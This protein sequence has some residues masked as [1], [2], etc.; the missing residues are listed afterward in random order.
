M[1]ETTISAK[2]FFKALKELEGATTNSSPKTLHNGIR[3]LRERAEG[4]E[5]V[6][7][8]E[9]VDYI[10]NPPKRKK[11]STSSRGKASARR[12]ASVALSNEIVA[13]LRKVENDELAFGE[14]L[15]SY[16]STCTAK[17]IRDA[18]AIYAAASLPKNKAEALALFRGERANRVRTLRKMDQSRRATPW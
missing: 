16:S 10:A 5:G 7:F 17:A 15:D 12:P 14:V 18:A 13:A 9:L 6:K 4:F 3:R 1:F 2:Q 8:Q 11:V